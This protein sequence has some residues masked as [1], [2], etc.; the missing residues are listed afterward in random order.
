MIKP[1]HAVAA[2]HPALVLPPAPRAADFL[3]DEDAEQA[4]LSA[5]LMDPEAVRTARMLGSWS[6]YL[7]RH[8]QIFSALCALDDE[9]IPIDP[10][11]LSDELQRTG[12]LESSGG[13]DY[14]GF[15]VDAVPTAANVEYHAKIVAKR[16]A[17]RAL[18]RATSEAE[19]QFGSGA[20]I[21]VVRARL[22]EQ[23]A[24]TEDARKTTR[25]LDD[26]E[27]MAIV[28][29]PALVDGVLSSNSHAQLFGASESFKSFVALDIAVHVAI[30][31]DW[32]NHSVRRGLVVYIA[33]EGGF[34]MKHRVAASK[35]YHEYTGQLGIYFFLSSV[36]IS[37]SGPALTALIREISK[38]LPTAPAL[39][40]IDTKARNYQGNENATED[41]N[42]FVAGC[43]LLR[44]TFGSCVLIV[45][46]SG[47]TEADRGRG[48]SA[49]YAALDTEIQCSRDGDR[50]ALRCT[51][52]KDAAHFQELNFEVI[53]VGK[54]LVLKPVD[55]LAG[56]LDG[57]RLLC[58]RALHRLD[59]PSTYGQWKNEAGLKNKNSS[60]AKARDWLMT[61]AYVKSA[62]DK[63][64]L[65]TDSG[66]MA[67]S[68][69]STSSPPAVHKAPTSVSPPS[70]GLEDPTVD[71]AL[72]FA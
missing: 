4:V 21:E 63:K 57:N 19:A 71:R 27:I 45:H 34:G 7:A 46:H 20:P 9:G 60:F 24:E 62:A 36:A 37:P 6:F 51:K 52:Q 25:L 54:S 10:I 41:E 56:K 42:V 15:L 30:G 47:W 55:Q 72:G 11:T 61:Q 23:L 44:K 49:G 33:A 8:S 18:V 2:K 32:H 13:K 64:Y 40:V 1:Q 38:R 68:P 26:E 43:D 22:F 70:G 35:R 66:R 48:A 69:Q 50:I 16:A 28:E 3:W 31:M 17:Q 14:I 12:L 59:G 65:V 39:I 58:L 67:V 29:P 53:S 5:M